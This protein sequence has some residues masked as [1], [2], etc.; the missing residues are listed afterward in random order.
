MA[1]DD[2]PTPDPTIAPGEDRVDLATDHELVQVMLDARDL[3]AGRDESGW[4]ELA[5][6]IERILEVAG[7]DP[8]QGLR[9]PV[10][11]DE[12]VED[13]ELLVGPATVDHAA[14]SLAALLDLPDDD[15]LELANRAVRDLET[16]VG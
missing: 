9:E 5:G 6:R 14:A 12:A 11:A 3:A 1:S 13:P 2:T 8:E 10:P 15:Q 7:I 4:R 16:A